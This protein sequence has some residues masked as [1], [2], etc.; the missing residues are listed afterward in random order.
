MR[1][2]AKTFLHLAVAIGAPTVA[3]AQG[4][5][6]WN[7]KQY[8]EKRAQKSG[9]TTAELVAACIEAEQASLSELREAWNGYTADSR[10]KCLRDADQ[11]YADLQACIVAAEAQHPEKK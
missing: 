6:Q 3:F 5:P 4:L 2:S 1:R 11:H 7:I 10:A 9:M 8:C